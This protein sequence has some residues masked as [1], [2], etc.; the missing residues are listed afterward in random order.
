MT[1]GPAIDAVIFDWGG[2]LTPWHTVDLARQWHVWAEHYASHES[3]DGTPQ[4][5]AALARRMVTAEAT[6]WRR[7]RQDGSSARL[8]EVLQA[9]G[10]REDH[11][12]YAGA[13]AAYEE[14][15]EPHTIVDP[16]VPALLA[17][18]RER[19]IRTGVLS[20]TIWS[21]EYHERVFARDGVLELIDGA[22]YTSEIPYVKPHP[23]AFEAAMSAVGC[24]VAGRCVYV[25][26]RPFEDVFGAQ[27]A[28]MRAVLVPHSDIPQAQQVPV[29]VSPDAVV[30]ELR[31]VLDVVDG[32]NA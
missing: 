15:W 18:L 16:Q 32:W 3:E 21:R 17:G 30:H 23:A 14:F 26:D 25:G 22:V 11:P 13:Q 31:E 29:E 28:G 6:A 10:I 19:G 20:N 2:T 9:V 4:D 27:R 1:G 7:L 24:T 8:T 5:P 12:G